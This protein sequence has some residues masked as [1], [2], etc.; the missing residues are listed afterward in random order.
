M[1]LRLINILLILT[2]ALKVNANNLGYS[3]SKPLVIGIDQDYPPLEYVDEKGKPSGTDVE[4]S[5]ILMKRINHHT[6][7]NLTT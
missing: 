4:F 7:I 5:K 6:Q 2:F 1:E 3:D